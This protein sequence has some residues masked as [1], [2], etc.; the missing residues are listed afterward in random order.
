VTGQGAGPT[1]AAYQKPEIKSILGIDVA[2]GAYD[3]GGNAPMLTAITERQGLQNAGVP[4][5][6]YSIPGGHTF[7]FWRMA[8]RDFLEHTAFR[9]TATSVTAGAGTLTATVSPATPEPAKPTGTVQFIAGGKLLGNPVPLVDGVATLAAND[10]A[11]ATSVS[12]VY[13]GDSLYNVSTS[14]IVSYEATSAVG[15]ITASVP[16]TLSLSLGAPASFGNFT[17][18]QAKAYEASTTGTVISTAGDAAL[19]VADP[20]TTAPGRLV[21]GTFSLAQPVEVALSKSAWSAP[22]SN[23]PVTVNFRQRVEANDPLRTG[24]YSKPFTFTLSTTTP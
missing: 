20:S 11:G 17:P 12:A 15:A 22:A 9:A 1:A 7:T 13:A 14:P 19:T 24:S 5:R 2:I 23:D 3:L 8:L 18:G 21:N 10:T 16:A 4:F 6:W